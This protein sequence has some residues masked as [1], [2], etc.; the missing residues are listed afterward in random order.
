MAPYIEEWITTDPESACMA[1]KL[2]SA[3]AKMGHRAPHNYARVH[4]IVA[5]R[6]KIYKDTRTDQRTKRR[7]CST[8]WSINNARLGI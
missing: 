7:K 6:G 3:R 1:T 2:R 5:Q 8:P 4:K